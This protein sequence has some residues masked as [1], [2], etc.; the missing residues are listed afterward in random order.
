MEQVL[1]YG[2]GVYLN[3]LCNLG[4]TLH[5]CK[6]GEPDGVFYHAVIQESYLCDF[7]FAVINS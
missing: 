7:G 2:M 3:L 5:I 4:P 6:M 1:Q